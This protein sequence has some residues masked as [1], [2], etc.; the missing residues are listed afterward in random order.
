LLNLRRSQVVRVGRLVGIEH[1]GARL[2]TVSV[3]DEVLP[4]TVVVEM[5]PAPVLDASTV[6]ATGVEAPPPS[7]LRL[8]VNPGEYTTGEA[9]GV[10]A[11]ASAA[12]PMVSVNWTCGAA[13]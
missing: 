1:Y 11:I 13:S 6:K 4:V 8:T 10:K 9:G 5:V 7:A 3:A 2:V 12:L